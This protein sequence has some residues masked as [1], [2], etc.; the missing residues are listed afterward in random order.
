VESESAGFWRKGVGALGTSSVP[1]ALTYRRTSLPTT[2]PEPQPAAA[3]TGEM[4][5]RATKHFRAYTVL[6]ESG[7]N[8]IKRSWRK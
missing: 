8:L 7:T 2:T 3:S 4:Q 1:Q 6:S 5:G